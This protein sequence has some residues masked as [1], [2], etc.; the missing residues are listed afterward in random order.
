MDKALIF[1]EREKEKERKSER[2]RN[3]VS[4]KLMKKQDEA[5][6]V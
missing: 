1:E 2:E 5:K 4:I 3:T 6:F